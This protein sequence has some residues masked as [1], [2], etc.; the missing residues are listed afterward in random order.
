MQLPMQQTTPLFGVT[1]PWSRYPKDMNYTDVF[2]NHFFPSLQ[3]K[4][5]ILD[6]YLASPHCSCHNMVVSD[7]IRFNCPDKKDPDSVVS[8]VCSVLLMVITDN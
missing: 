8:T 2:F 5:A 1:I 4:A 7:K 6:K 3:G